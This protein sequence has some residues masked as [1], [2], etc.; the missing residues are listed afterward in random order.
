MPG[1]AQNCP[2]A[3]RNP[4]SAGWR[5]DHRAIRRNDRSRVTALRERLARYQ[6]RI[7]RVLDQSLA[8]PDAGTPRLRD[9]MRYSVLAGGKRLRPLLVYTT[10]EAL[11]AR[12]E[13]LDCVA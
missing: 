7:E 12:I 5:R 3:G 11:G 9:A 2:T 6:Q 1:C 4:A 8:L 13:A 10:G